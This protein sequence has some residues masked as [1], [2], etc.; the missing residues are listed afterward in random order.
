[1]YVVRCVRHYFYLA[2]F[3]ADVSSNFIACSSSATSAT[4]Y[5]QL[6]FVMMNFEDVE[7]RDGTFIDE[8][9]FLRLIST[10]EC[11]YHG[12]SG[13]RRESRRRGQWYPYPHFI[14]RSRL[15]KTSRPCS[16]SQLHVSRLV[17][18]FSIRTGKFGL[19]IWGN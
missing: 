6:P 18:P 4:D 15:E 14:H 17:E 16:T 3:T 5:T 10:Q 9:L 2:V 1:M 7:E 19:I 11:A 13:R 8:S 12:T